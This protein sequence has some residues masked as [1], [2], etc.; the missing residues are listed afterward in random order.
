MTILKRIYKI[1]D[2]LLEIELEEILT[3]PSKVRRKGLDLT[4]CMPS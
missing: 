4:T 1:L 3:L 2:T